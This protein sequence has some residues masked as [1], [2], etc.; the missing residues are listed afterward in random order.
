[1]QCGTPSRKTHLGCAS[2]REAHWGATS[3]AL[4]SGSH[5]PPSA[6]TNQ[7]ASTSVVHVHSFLQPEPSCKSLARVFDQ[8]RPCSA[9]LSRTPFP[10]QDDSVGVQLRKSVIRG[11]S[12]TQLLRLHLPQHVMHAADS[13]HVRCVL[14]N[15]V[16]EEISRGAAQPSAPSPVP[17]VQLLSADHA[18]T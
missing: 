17:Y 1:M 13:A 6:D 16:P 4:L 11:D 10:F 5:T 9:T 12:A 14:G 2:T 18:S 3:S 15:G 7:E 8:R